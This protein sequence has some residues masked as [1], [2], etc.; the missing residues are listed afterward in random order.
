MSTLRWQNDAPYTAPHSIPA[1][2]AEL[3]L[4]PTEA[5]QLFP[6]PPRP[7]MTSSLSKYS[8][9]AVPFT[10]QPHSPP[11]LGLQRCPEIFQQTIPLG[12]KPVFL[13]SSSHLLVMCILES[14]TEESV[15]VG[16][17]VAP[18]A[19]GAQALSLMPSSVLPGFSCSLRA[20]CVNLEASMLRHSFSVSH[21]GTFSH[22]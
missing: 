21:F 20:G 16:S 15:L 18:S 4:L 6:A 19:W 2:C 8:D 11:G 22:R 13:P 1:L 5:I 17:R 12:G 7:L 10:P 3:A 9:T 14:S